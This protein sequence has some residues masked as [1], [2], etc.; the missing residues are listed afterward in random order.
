M[1]LCGAHKLLI[2]TSHVFRRSDFNTPLQYFHCVSTASNKRQKV[3]KQTLEFGGGAPHYLVPTGVESGGV[4]V[5]RESARLSFKFPV[6]IHLQTAVETSCEQEG[7]KS[8]LLGVCRYSSYLC[9]AC[10]LNARSWM[11]S[12][13]QLYPSFLP[14]FPSSPLLSPLNNLASQNLHILLET[15]ILASCFPSLCVS[16]SLSHLVLPWGQ[17]PT[18]PSLSRYHSGTR[19][20]HEGTIKRDTYL[21]PHQVTL[22][23]LLQRKIIEATLTDCGQQHLLHLAQLKKRKCQK[24][25]DGSGYVPYS[26]TSHI[27]TLCNVLLH[28]SAKSYIVDGLSADEVL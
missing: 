28:S 11:Q 17:Q 14:F 12:P 3:W 10:G 9:S 7:E 16:L 26:Y 27:I 22:V 25:R 20:L 4:C 18:W 1:P 21:K 24:K 13:I 2:Q 15:R 19:H 8:M 5:G 23:V 6:L